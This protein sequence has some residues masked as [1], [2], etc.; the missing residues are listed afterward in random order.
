MKMKKVLAILLSVAVLATVCVCLVAC[1]EENKNEKVVSFQPLKK[2]DIKF[3]LITLHDTTS[4]Y[5]KNF[6][7]AAKQ[8]VND[9]GLDEKTQLVIISDIEEN[10]ACYNAAVK[11]VNQGCNVIFAD[12][13]GHEPFL[14]QAA[15]EFPNVRFAHA[16]GTTAH[17]ELIGNFYNAFAS[18]YEGR[19]L[20][21]VAAGMK[22]KDMDEKGEIKEDNKVNG[23]VKI[24]Y[25]AAHPYAEVIS[26]YTSFYL[27]VRSVY[28]NVT[29]EVTYT[30]SWYDP[31]AESAAATKLIN[32]KCVLISQ[33]A[34]S[35]GAPNACK[36]KNIPNV[37][38][39]IS[40]K[41]ACPDSYLIG[42]RINWIPYFKYLLECAIDGVTAVGFDYV[43]S[44]Q[45]GSVTITEINEKVA[46]PGT[47]EKLEEVKQGLINGTIKVFDIKNFTV[48]N[49]KTLDVYLADVD[50]DEGFTPDTQVV[51]DG[52]FMESYYRSAPYFNV[53]IDGIK[54]IDEKK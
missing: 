18:I 17:T 27:G 45:D 8:A 31:D 30:L 3:G 43:G 33:H 48:D 16:T 14:A 12:S 25:V 34:D 46:A 15:E 36:E 53:I 23:K 32:N 47:A 51:K 28:E 40:T 9:M 22:L 4:T 35:M 5:D 7:D 21:G 37:T 54:I 20:A 41:E 10:E 1:G 42:S 2:E 19:Y 49:G 24:G 6:I 38:Y 11:L 26:G 50:S 13:F 39:N 52:V 44:L 29:M